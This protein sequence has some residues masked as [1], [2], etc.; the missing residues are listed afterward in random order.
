M[1]A[2]PTRSSARISLALALWPVLLYLPLWC[3]ASGALAQQPADRPAAEAVEAAQPEMQPPAES[4]T[5]LS[6]VWLAL[7]IASVSVWLYGTGWVFKDAM[8]VG[9][10]FRLWTAI[11]LGAGLVG[12]LFTI[13]VHAAFSFLLLVCVGSVFALYVRGRNRIV[14]EQF[15]LFVK[16]EVVKAPAR[17]VAVGGTEGEEEPARMAVSL[18]NEAQ[19]SMDGFLAD[20][21]DLSEAAEVMGD[22]IGRASLARARAVRVEATGVEYVARFNLDGMSQQIEALPLSLGQAVVACAARFAGHKT[23]SGAGRRM[24]AILPGDERVEL[25]ARAV[26]SKKGPA[27]IMS[28]PDW[29]RDL[30]KGGLSALGMHGSMAGKVTEATEH[31]NCAVLV[32]GPPGSGRTSTLHAII[33]QIDIF[34]TDV[35]T[36]EQKIEHNLD[37]VVRHEVEMESD[38]AFQNVFE[39]VVREEPHV[40]AADELTSTQQAALLFEYAE[41]GG[42]VLA[43]MQAHHAGQEVQRL[44]QGVDAGLVS[45]TVLCVLNQRLL[46]KLCERCKEP[47]TPNRRTLAKLEIDP[48]RQGTWFRPVGCEQCF[49]TGYHGRTAVFELLLV[50]DRVREVI[51]GGRASADAV[52]KAA[53]AEGLRTLLHDGILKVRQGITTV[54]EVRRVLR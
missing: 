4:G 24:T 49:G 52:R 32:S 37:Q 15:R 16:K 7:V 6:L 40:I 53:G 44:V 28:L 48:Q 31:S 34:T 54:D 26:K 35:V 33:R 47:M 45:R 18:L 8:A 41:G 43:T 50:N 9:M 12:L 5:Y 1:T 29:T 19:E 25:V 3:A 22:L 27:L 42:R 36:L 23:E 46:R 2:S 21:P 17:K 20:Q 14:P 13:L 39:G 30:Y 51:R 11:M 10:D 38:E